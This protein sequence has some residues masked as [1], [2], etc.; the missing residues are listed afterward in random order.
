MKKL[1]SYLLTTTLL[2][3]SGMCCPSTASAAWTSTAKRQVLTSSGVTC[4][5][6]INISEPA[7]TSV[8]NGQ[9][10]HRKKVE[11]KISF[12]RKEDEKCISSNLL[13]FYFTYNGTNAAVD[14]NQ[15]MVTQEDDLTKRWKT[16]S[17]EEIYV[18]SG[19]SVVSQRI[20]IYNRGTVF[21]DF[22]NTDE[23]HVDVICSKTGD[24]TFNIKSMDELQVD[25]LRVSGLSVKKEQVKKKLNRV[26]SEKTIE[27]IRDL[28]TT[29]D[30]LYRYN[31]KEF[32]I[33]Y[34]DQDDKVLGDSTIQVCI[35]YNKSTHEVQCL[36]TS[37]AEKSK[38][39]DV[40]MRSGNET[41]TSG[42]A[43]GTIKI[44]YTSK[45]VK[46]T[47]REVLAIKCDYNGNITN[48]FIQ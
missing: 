37:H 42:G 47:H 5:S 33:V 30:D 14:E 40:Y 36:S 6:E 18:A 31:T 12:F 25:D 17:S 8:K 11:V 35:R 9:S 19:Q 38:D 28:R 27:N 48:S 43:Y 44:K 41:R 20:G 10:E 3:V 13:S 16:S 46:K 15:L 22:K 45:G 7:L 21:N 24:V 4:I 32:H 39:I 26:V 1:L 2:F 23:F 34:T 29:E